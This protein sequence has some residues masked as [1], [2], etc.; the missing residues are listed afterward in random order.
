M[1]K[2]R[3]RLLLLLLLVVSVAT[4]LVFQYS[5]GPLSA[6]PAVEVVFRG[7]T[8]RTGLGKWAILTVTNKDRW[9]VFLFGGCRAIFQTRGP[10][11][12]VLCSVGP[13]NLRRGD[14]FV[15]L[16]AAPRNEGQW[17][18]HW[19]MR[20]ITLKERLL[21]AAGRYRGSLP[22]RSEPGASADSGWMHAAYQTNYAS[23]IARLVGPA[24]PAERGA[25][26]A[27]LRLLK[28]IYWL[29]LAR[30]DGRNLDRILEDALGS[31]GLGNEAAALTKESLL[32]NL[33]IAGK[34]GCL[35]AAGLA[36]LRQDKAPT[37]R[38]GPG[39]GRRV[40][41]RSHHPPRRLPGTGQLHRQSGI[42]A[43]ADEGSQE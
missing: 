29:K 42:D 11:E 18:A 31:V 2:P 21:A 34:L 28:A 14:G 15:A 10:P 27:N 4:L 24:T 22:F 39:Q 7:Y 32:R 37:V 13:T 12:H 33:D 16:V 38:G 41:C 35:D 20:R 8:N 40:K 17:Q 25:R 9:D 6:G 5:K 43:L 23:C 1:V 19:G 36:D 3:L 30:L 26:V